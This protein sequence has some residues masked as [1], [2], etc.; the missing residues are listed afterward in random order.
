M[1]TI[2]VLGEVLSSS[3]HHLN[4]SADA[5]RKP[6]ENISRR[7]ALSGRGLV[8]LKICP[9]SQQKS[10]DESPSNAAD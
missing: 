2:L 6:T 10:K 4:G 9:L 7:C 8:M 5:R 3:E 1:S